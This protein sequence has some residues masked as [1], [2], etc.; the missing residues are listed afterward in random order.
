MPKKIVALSI[1]LAIFLTV[2]AQNG[3]TSR[4]EVLK[5]EKWW[6]AFVGGAPLEPFDEPF[7]IHTAES[8][9]GGFFVPVLVSSAGRYIWSDSPMEIDFD[10]SQFLI[11]SETEKVEVKKAGRTLREAY[12]LCCHHHF[13]PSAE[14]RLPAELFTRPIYETEYDFGFLQC[15]DDILAYA[16]RL[17]AEGF[18]A[19][20]ILLADGWRP[21]SGGYDFDRLYYPDPK[22]F[23]DA[24]HA[25]GFEVMLTVTP[26]LSASGRAY[27][28]A[29]QNGMLYEEEPGDP[30]EV[31]NRNGCFVAIDVTKEQLC[32]TLRA[33]LRR[34]T[35]DYG[36]DGFR[37]D[38]LDLVPH[39][40]R[41]DNRFDAYL[42]GWMSLGSEFPLAEFVPGG[43][44]PQTSCASCMESAATTPEAY[45]NDVLVAGLSGYTFL[46]PA[47]EILF[48]RSAEEETVARAFILGMMMPVAYVPFAPW[49]VADETLY[50]EMRQTLAFRNSKKDYLEQIAQ[51]AALAAEPIVRHLEYQFPRSGFADCNDQ[52][53]LGSRLL[54]V[55]VFD[56]AEERLVRLPRGVWKDQEGRRYRGPLVLNAATHGRHLICYELQ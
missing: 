41:T 4:I 30:V 19:G 52:F 22:E 9:E 34:L 10:G 6:G 24:L 2:S 49:R 43:R 15:A 47:S 21:A 28:A 23:V 27:V 3:A 14:R 46:R 5:G 11:T 29:L 38:C 36:V 31:T 17:L 20:V 7:R 45:L 42:A 16:D 54:V 39:L 8:A 55:P 37:F 18:P 13:P 33:E 51:E 12:L 56:G 32:D 53:M 40:L 26:Y 35:D 50:D 1:F 25:K 44:M 48:S